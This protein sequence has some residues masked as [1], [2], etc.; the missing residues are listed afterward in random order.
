MKTKNINIEDYKNE[1]KLLTESQI[2]SIK[3]SF[4][5]KDIININNID[6][7]DIINDKL[8][9]GIYNKDTKT[10]D[11]GIGDIGFISAT[12]SKVFQN[13]G[14]QKFILDKL[15]DLLRIRKTSNI[16][17]QIIYNVATSTE[18]N[19]IGLHNCTNAIRL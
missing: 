13:D 8:I 1:D 17:Q 9:Q 14:F 10:F 16:N 4:C 19:A 3:D 15:E 5:K 12:R 18:N 11:Y 6:D 2:E 7:S